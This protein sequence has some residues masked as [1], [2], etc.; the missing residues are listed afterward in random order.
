[1]RRNEALK[2]VKKRSNEP[3]LIESETTEIDPD[4]GGPVCK[5][6]I[7]RGVLAEET[8]RY[9]DMRAY[10]TMLSQPQPTARQRLEEFADSLR[11]NLEKKNLPTDRNPLWM[12]VNGGPW[13]PRAKDQPLPEGR[14]S[15]SHWDH[16]LKKPTDPLSKER[17]AGELLALIIELLAIDGI[18]PHLNLIGRLMNKAGSFRIAGRLNFLAHQAIAGQRARAKGPAAKRRR[19]EE[20]CGIVMTHAAAHWSERPLLRGDI[21]N[22]AAC[23]A[24]VVNKELR[25]RNLLSPKSNGLSIKTIGDHIRRGTG[26]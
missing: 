15:Q 19:A 8:R 3:P 20:T 10:F 11:D 17:E 1:M 9:D 5:T 14:V 23:I 18:D 16:R 6:R 24:G 13:V 4:T 22:T 2:L 21:S 7:E 26:G 25:S 12:S